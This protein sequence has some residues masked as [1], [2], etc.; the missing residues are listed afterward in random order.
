MKFVKIMIVICTDNF[1][2]SDSLI[3]AFTALYF[4]SKTL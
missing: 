3:A 2:D 1:N 4:Y